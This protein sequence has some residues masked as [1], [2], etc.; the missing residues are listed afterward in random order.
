M[1]IL[2]AILFLVGFTAEAQILVEEPK[3][4][5]DAAAEYFKKREPKSASRTTS[6]FEGS[7]RVLM[8]HAGTFINDKAYRWGRDGKTEDPGE[9]MFGVT[10]RVGEWKRSMDLMVRADL[11]SY[12]IDEVTPVKLSIMPIVAFPDAR[13]EFPLYFG[14]GMGAG[15]FFKQAGDESDL[16]FDYALLIGARFS[17]LLDSGI[18][19]F[20]ETGLKGQVHLLSSGQQDG[21]F[22]A[23]GA[24]FSF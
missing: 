21:V 5:R 10:Y 4:G 24:I 14:L 7:D 22:L 15:V 9:A 16:S 20:V 11:I 18:G 19:L 13:S 8:L 1:K 23:T 3:V 17:D 12:S 6:S 2:I